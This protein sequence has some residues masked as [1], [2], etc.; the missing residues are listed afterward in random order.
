MFGYVVVVVG[1]KMMGLE[2]W[3]FGCRLFGLGKM[4]FGCMLEG[5]GNRHFGWML[6]GLGKMNHGCMMVVQC[7]VV[8][9]QMAPV[10]V[11]GYS[12]NNLPTHMAWYFFYTE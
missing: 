8:V 4:Y 5:L 6:V 11:V 9:R 10:P 2:K 12:S 3:Y 1:C 7:Y